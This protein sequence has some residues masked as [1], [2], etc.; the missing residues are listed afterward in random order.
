MT[1]K[2][3][4]SDFV[5]SIAA[6]GIIEAVKTYNITCP[7]IWTDA[8]IVY[9]IP[10]GTVVAP[11]DTLCIL[12]AGEIEN[13][14]KEAVKELETCRAEYNKTVADLNLQALLLESQVKIIESSAAISQLDS[15]WLNFASDTQ[16]RLIELK[17]Q[18]AQIEKEKIQMK[19]QFLK[20]IN[21][22]ELKKMESKIRQAENRAA[23]EKEKLDKLT[24]TADVAGIV[25]YDIL[26]TSG[27]K[28]KEGDIVWGKMPILLI[29]DM[30][31]MHIKLEVNE[32][33][34][35]RIQK[36]QD[37][38]I[39][40]DA[41]PEVKF[42]GKIDRKT[43]M[44]K[45]IKRNSKIKVFEVFATIDSLNRRI[46]SGLSV[47]CDVILEFLP[48]TVVVPLPA[49]FEKDSTKHVYVANGSGYEK[50]QVTLSYNSDNFAVVA[51]GLEKDEEI[52]LVQPP[53]DLLVL[54]R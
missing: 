17:L 38:H 18:K 7:G 9:L 44:G 42:C 45:P 53:D 24:L 29:P 11:G 32:T 47:T 28:V 4:K 20:D 2:I 30:S 26:R 50:R 5:H 14:Y 41:M 49:V 23:Q 39:T 13:E 36:D 35:K 6:T 22:S 37:I 21:E 10:E 31:A 48:D 12:K 8:T 3:Q 15:S 1:H 52:A 46:Q 16:K 34:F 43:P 33:K 51:E 40:I 19:L 27:N 25:N 54:E